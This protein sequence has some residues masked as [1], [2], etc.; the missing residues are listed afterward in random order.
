M[1]FTKNFSYNSPNKFF[2]ENQQF[3]QFN[4]EA[5]DIFEVLE[6]VRP[7]II[8]SSTRG[9]FA[10]QVIMHEHLIEYTKLTKAKI[11]FLS[12][13][14]VFDSYSKYPSYESDKTLSESRYGRFKIKIENMLMRLPKQQYAILRLPMVFGAQSP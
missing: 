12:S 4:L 2:R 5:D 6:K 10:T 9:D 11:I 3:Y 13:A 8:V 14:N 7:S 1:Q